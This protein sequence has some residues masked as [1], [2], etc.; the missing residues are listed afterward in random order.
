VPEP[1]EDRREAFTLFE[2]GRYRE[3]Y[4]RCRALLSQA[5]DPAVLVLAASNLYYLE[6]YDQAELHFRD[7]LERMPESSHVHSFLGRI[8]ERHGD[9][10]AVESYARALALDADNLEALR[11]Y[12][13]F[14]M[15]GGDFRRA[16]SVFE[17]VARRE[18]S[19]ADLR[20]WMRALNALGDYDRSIRVYGEQPPGNMPFPEYIDALAGAG[21]YREAAEEAFVLYR[22]VQDPAL[23]ARG[24]SCLARRDPRE[25]IRR[26]RLLSAE[27]RTPAV[28]REFIAI[29]RKSGDIAGA[30]SE[31]ESLPEKTPV[32][33][34]AVCELTATAGR[35]DEALQLYRALIRDALA[36]LEDEQSLS[37]I[38]DSFTD[39]L[40]SRFPLRESGPILLELAGGNPHVIC[41]LTIAAFY[42]KTGEMG[43]ARAYYYRAYRAE[44][45]RGGLEYARFLL[46]TGDMREAEKV[47]LYLMTHAKKT[48][49]IVKAGRVVASFPG[50]GP[51]MKRANTRIRERL[52]ERL[53][54]L[55][56]DGLEMLALFLLI[57]ATDAYEHGDYRGCKQY[58]L[59]GIDVLPPFS[60]T[61]THQDFLSVLSGCKERVL[62]DMPV[63]GDRPDTVPASTPTAAVESLGDSGMPLDP[64]ERRIVGFLREHREVTEADLRQFLGT[65]RVTGIVNRLI[66]RASLRGV[67]LIGRKGTGDK[68]EVYEYIG[69]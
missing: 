36:T 41:L 35:R 58:C 62:A 18:R 46:R 37:A 44:Y 31:S 38:F 34:L 10:S 14:L 50:T 5:D 33:R 39:F 17:R 52:M 13:G 19:E 26:I 56:P 69:E 68:G 30:L 8:L 21:R 63:F 61:V 1:D 24:L 7:L 43:D 9:E 3:S 47:F 32:D 49:D 2:E 57:S 16:A 27:E 11:S 20:A 65:R 60:G 15:R 28:C 48:A 23:L 12:G 29:L 45:L 4:E 42:E 59:Q 53:P 22:S 64:M 66:Q 55:G 40:L 51:K 67:R 54:R 6:E 25:A